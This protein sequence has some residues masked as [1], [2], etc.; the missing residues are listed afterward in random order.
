MT[1]SGSAMPS[2]WK[3]GWIPEVSSSVWIVALSV[4]GPLG[5]AT[6]AHQAQLSAVVTPPQ[7][8]RDL[9]EFCFPQ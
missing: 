3:A 6:S 8:I 1:P 9:A 5:E 2:C 7:A 4:H